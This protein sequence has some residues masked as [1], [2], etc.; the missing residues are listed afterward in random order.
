MV[1]HRL[2]DLASYSKQVVN[3]DSRYG[4]LDDNIDADGSF[5]TEEGQAVG[6]PT[7]NGNLPLTA[8]FAT[9]LPPLFDRKSN[10][11]FT[12][13]NSIYQ[14]GKHTVNLPQ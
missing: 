11:K 3:N 6:F 8:V 10:S 5:L 2:I 1:C 9:F 14:N 13:V 7:A 12:A 4:H